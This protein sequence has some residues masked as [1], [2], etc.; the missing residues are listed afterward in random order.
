LRTDFSLPDGDGFDLAHRFR[1]VHPQ[2]E[3]I[4]VSGS[5][6]ELDIRTEGLEHFAMMG[7]PFKFHELLRMVRAWV[8]DTTPS[9]CH[10][11]VSS[12][13]G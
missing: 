12:A 8:A 10:A 13:R 6:A 3:I 9:A 7:K 11:L 2:P 5:M 1:V 4:L